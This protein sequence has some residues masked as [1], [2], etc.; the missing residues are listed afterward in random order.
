MKVLAK[1]NTIWFCNKFTVAL[2]VV[3]MLISGC[4]RPEQPQA[5]GNISGLTWNWRFDTDGRVV[6]IKAPGNF[7][8]RVTYSQA[9]AKTGQELTKIVEVGSDR[10]TFTWN[11]RGDL[12]VAEGPGGKMTFS[13]NAAGLPT[14]F[15]SDGAP[16]LRYTYDLKDRLTEKRIGES[17]AFQYRYDYLGRLTAIATHVGD[18]TYK[19]HHAKNIV[20]RR[21]PNGIQT[22]R[23]YDDEGKLIKLTHIDSENYIIAKYA[24]VY[25]ADGLIRVVSETNQSNGERVCQYGYGLMQRL[26]SVECKGDGRSYH[27]NYDELGNLAESQKE[28]GQMLRFTSTPAGAIKTDSRGDLQVDARGH[29]RKLPHLPSSINYDFNDAGELAAAKGQSVQYTYNTLGLLTSRM[30]EGDKTHYLPDPFAD[31]WQPLWRKNIDGTEDV[32][33]WDGAVPL[34]ELKGKEVRYRLEDHLGSVRVEV[35]RHGKIIAWRDY[36]PYGEPEVVRVDGNLVPAYASLFW[37]PVAKVYLTKARAYDPVTGRFLQP[38]PQLRTPDS[39]KHNH[40]LYAYSGGDPVNFVDRNGAEAVSVDSRSVWWDVFG[41]SLSKWRFPKYSFGRKGVHATLSPPLDMPQRFDDG[42]AVKRDG[43]RMQPGE[44]KRFFVNTVKSYELTELQRNYEGKSIFKLSQQDQAKVHG[45]AIKKFA[46]N[47]SDYPG[48]HIDIKGPYF[49]DFNQYVANMNILTEDGWTSVDW[50]TTVRDSKRTFWFSPVFQMLNPG[51]R[52]KFGK[53]M[54]NIFAPRVGQKEFPEGSVFE[55]PQNNLNSISLIKRVGSM[56]VGSAVFTPGGI[57]GTSVVASSRPLT[58]AEYSAWKTSKYRNNPAKSGAQ[59]T[60]WNQF[61]SSEGTWRLG[62]GGGPGGTSGPSRGPWGTGGSNSSFSM[63]SPSPVGGVYLGGAGKAL[64]GLGQIKGVSI[65]EMTGKLVLI[66]SNEQKI[67]LPPLRLNDIVTIFR[68]VYD[69]GESPS[70]TIDPDEQNPKG[71]TM[72]VKHGPGTEGT[73]VGWILFECD[74]IM[75]TYQLGEDNVTRDA[76]VSKIPGYTDMLDAIYFGGEAK[77]TK[78]EGLLSRVIGMRNTPGQNWERFWIVP[79]AVRRFNATTDNLS[80]F[81]LTL[82]VNTQK[83]RWE[84]GK[85]VDDEEGESSFGANEFKTWF[86]NRYDEIADEVFLMP[87]RTVASRLPLQSFMNCAASH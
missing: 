20:I 32:I 34:L 11:H 29:V 63:H 66:G 33:V 56:S 67:A 22:F 68:A 81:E 59:E 73:Y 69:H 35:N 41:N 47:Y 44:A 14:E 15:R 4:E 43:T 72:D 19:Y 75:K 36:A 16:T 76:V 77:V 83:M 84:G 5:D 31:A 48:H 79:A 13:R 70:V 42:S 25:R 7:V 55:I 12:L 51:Q 57:M 82:K 54:H 86:S 27:Y 39:H 85:L 38:D 24:Y 6:E 62:G 40:S 71:P 60:Y 17:T 1:H 46:K 10:R 26:L 18:I 58:T 52:L 80:L 78:S 3:G 65:D 28:G 87:R 64:E 50:T 61:D 53:V 49:K 9:E 8:T 30:V 45:I 37:D 2:T 74:R 21:L 23:E